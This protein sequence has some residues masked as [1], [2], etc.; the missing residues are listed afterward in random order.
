MSNFMASTSNWLRVKN[1]Q[2]ELGSVATEFERV[3]YSEQLARCQ[4][5]YEKN[6]DFVSGDRFSG[7]VTSGQ[8]YYANLPFKVQKR[9][10]PTLA[11]LNPSG[12]SFPVAT[13]SAGVN[14]DGFYEARV[15]NS[16]GTG[17]FGCDWTA[18]AEL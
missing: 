17:L 9:A 14:A 5:Y 13:G 3:D 1:V 2:V 12:M 18:S 16:T 4:R 6:T 8:T 15:A 10:T 7:N 11:L